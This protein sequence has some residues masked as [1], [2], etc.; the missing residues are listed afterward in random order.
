[1][2]EGSEQRQEGCGGG[3]WYRNQALPRRLVIH[4]QQRPSDLFAGDDLGKRGERGA[5]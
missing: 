5:P 1:M 4:Q 2:V 3:R